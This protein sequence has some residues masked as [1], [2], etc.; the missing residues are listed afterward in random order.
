MTA[1][2]LLN[3]LQIAWVSLLKDDSITDSNI[4]TAPMKLVAA[5][6]EAAA[7]GEQDVHL[8]AEGALV[9]WHLNDSPTALH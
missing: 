1:P 2:K 8:L 4:G 3:A 6:L 5:V 9:R 7:S